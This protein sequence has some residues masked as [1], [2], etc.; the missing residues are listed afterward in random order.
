[1]PPCAPTASTATAVFAKVII[2][3]HPSAS[4]LRVVARAGRNTGTGCHVRRHP[5]TI[6][7]RVRRDPTLIKLV[8]KGSGQLMFARAS[9]SERMCGRDGELVLDA[10]QCDIHDQSSSACG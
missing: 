7:R 9:R 2:Q 4:S 10:R 1:V 5:G 6:D 8:R 3:R